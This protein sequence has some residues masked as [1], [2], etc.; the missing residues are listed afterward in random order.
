M[1]FAALVG[2]QFLGYFNDNLYK[3]VVSLIA[4]DVALI[5]NAGSTYLSLTGVLFV[6]PYVLF[7]GYAGFLADRFDKRLVLIIMKAVEVGL[8]ILAAAALIANG[9]VFLL[10]ILFLIATQA[11]FFSPAKYAILP[12]IVAPEE[13]A[14]ANGWLESSRYLAIILGTVAGGVLLTVLQNRPD[15]IGAVLLAVAASGL[16][17]SLLI[18]RPS[19]KA[20]RVPFRSSPWHEVLA[21]IHQIL[22]Y[23]AITFAVGGITA[24]DYLSTLATLDILLAGKT[25]MGASNLQIGL[26]GAV[27]AIGAGT[28][29]IVA[30]RIAR[31]QIRH[32]VA[33]VGMV[34]IGVMLLIFGA[35]AA[36]FGWAMAVAGPLGFF[37]GFVIVPLNALIQEQAEPKERGRIIASANFL[38]MLG[39]LLASASLWVLHDILG[40]SA[41]AILA[42]SG[43]AALILALGGLRFLSAGRLVLDVPQDRQM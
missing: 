25:V 12:E 13:L 30:G 35:I 31:R 26:L 22:R 7:S 17:L 33:L 8:M 34:G 27:L 32:R 15:L 41:L 23:A 37:G 5:G 28:G 2:T 29:S 1:G 36:S 3:M 43:C 10:T 11:T 42:L 14:R 24:F 18:G 4:I 38:S 19:R 16:S 6:L 21:G 20:E 39:C 9:M 40:A